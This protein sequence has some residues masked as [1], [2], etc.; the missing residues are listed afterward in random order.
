MAATEAKVIAAEAKA[1]PEPPTVHNVGASTRPTDVG[2]A[3]WKTIAPVML[4]RARVSLPRRTHSTLLSVSGSSVAIGAMMSA[5]RVPLTAS[6]DEKSVIARTKLQ[7]PP[8]MHARAKRTWTVTMN[9]LG[10]SGC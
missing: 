7:A 2:I 6:E 4:P 3:L 1:T 10:G 8:M 9:S 5:R